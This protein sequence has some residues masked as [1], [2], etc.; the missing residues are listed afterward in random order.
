MTPHRL[1]IAF[2][3]ALSATGAPVLAAQ[4][5]ERPIRMIVPFSAGGTA[6]FAA[7][8]VGESLKRRLGQ[9]VVVDN[10]GGA[11]SAL[12]TKLAA[13]A[14]P[15]GYTLLAT[16]VGLA[17]NETLRPDR[18]YVALEALAPVSLMGVT[19][20][21]LVVNRD[22]PYKSVKDLL[23]A[24]K[25]SS[26]KL[27]YGSAGAG[28]STHLSMEYLKSL[29]GIDLLHVPYKGGG[30]AV[31]AMMGGE[32]R[33]VMSPVPTV[34]AHIKAGRVRALAVSGA[35]RDATL[36]DL[37]TIAEAGVPGY[38]YTTWYGVLATGRTPAAIIERLNQAMVAA[39]KEPD[40]AGKLQKT[41]L[42][43]TP[44]TPREFGK[45]IAVEIAKWRKVVQD[46]GI[47]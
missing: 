13:D 30:P 40:T 38:E 29:A 32:V 23:A 35:A 42:E 7:R 6:D 25:A 43:P 36:P 1:S 11:G 15:D 18:G 46:A 22:S 19:P 14:T 2:A 47:Q 5:P 3:A 37:P 41:G 9:E 8:I 16:N 17:V 45:L 34:F 12:G 33:A 10:R 20:S 24:A 26:G 27:P 21:V 39:L 31:T 4:Y 44:T 28:S